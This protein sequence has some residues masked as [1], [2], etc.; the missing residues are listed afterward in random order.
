VT[1]DDYGVTCQEFVALVTE[2]LEGT[3]PPETEARVRLHLDR[4]EPCDEYLTQM[5][6]TIGALGHVPVESL[7]PRARDDIVAAFRGF[8][9]TG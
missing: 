6:T 5:R 7:S 2:Y 9:R 3:L 4:C 8:G 1:G